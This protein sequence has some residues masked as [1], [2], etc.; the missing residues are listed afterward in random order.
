MEAI[1]LSILFSDCSTIYVTQA[2]PSPLI[3]W[4]LPTPPLPPSFFLP[5]NSLPHS[6]GD[7]APSPFQVVFHS[8]P[9]P[10]N[11]NLGRGLTAN[12]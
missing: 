1:K 2:S 9:S 3:H 10:D 4:Q 6:R 7:P 8:H 11:K 5:P 12:C